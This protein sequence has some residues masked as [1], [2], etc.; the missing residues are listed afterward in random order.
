[1]NEHGI[2]RSHE[3]RSSSREIMRFKSRW[4]QGFFD[5]NNDD[6]E[7]LYLQ[8]IESM[9]D[10]Q[11]KNQQLYLDSFMQFVL[12][13]PGLALEAL[14]LG[15]ID[16]DVITKENLQTMLQSLCYYP[17]YRRCQLGDLR[18]YASSAYL[19]KD[20]LAESQL[21]GKLLDLPAA[22]NYSGKDFQAL[23]S[24]L[25]FKNNYPL[26]VKRN[27]LLIQCLGPKVETVSPLSFNAFIGNYADCSIAE[28]GLASNI[29]LFESVALELL[30]KMPKHYWDG[31]FRELSVNFQDSD[32]SLGS[33]FRETAA[34]SGRPLKAS[35]NMSPCRRLVLDLDVK[36]PIKPNFPAE[37]MMALLN[38]GAIYSTASKKNR[39]YFKALFDHC[40]ALVNAD[41]NV[42]LYRSICI[43]IYDNP[44]QSSLRGRDLKDMSKKM[45]AILKVSQPTQAGGSSKAKESPSDTASLLQGY[46]DKTVVRGLLSASPMAIYGSNSFD[47][48]I[49]MSSLA[50]VKPA[51][52]GS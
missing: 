5:S 2:L 16:T 36:Q 50:G 41:Q 32:D 27:L 38:K 44:G 8:M 22:S 30:N 7:W 4:F 14:N 34:I 48:G 29:V 42:S 1:M 13:V 11:S 43:H 21:L 26:T 46:P 51:A 23:L 20:Q 15:I 25:V 35:A 6:K 9:R 37:L 49:S 39:K 12:N 3:L 28:T 24:G 47:E 40:Y 33:L 52:V 10:M 18:Y 19:S 17:D 31:P 45:G